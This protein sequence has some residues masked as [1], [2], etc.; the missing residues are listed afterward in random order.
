MN[1]LHLDDGH[2]ASMPM[3]PVLP[4]GDGGW[5]PCPELLTEAEAIRYLRLDIKGPRHPANTLKYYRDRGLLRAVRVGRNLRYPRREL[6]AMI[7]RLIKRT[8]RSMK[9]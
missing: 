9:K 6:E 3:S 8:E 7:D 1:D 2:I 4:N 5:S